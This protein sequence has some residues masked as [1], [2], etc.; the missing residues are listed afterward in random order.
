MPRKPPGT[1]LGQ[2]KKTAII[3]IIIIIIIVNIFSIIIIDNKYKSYKVPATVIYWYIKKKM[4]VLTRHI[5]NTN[6][7]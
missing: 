4:M 6:S 5:T 3:I 1:K 7:V 2:K